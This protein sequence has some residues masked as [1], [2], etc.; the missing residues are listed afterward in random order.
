MKATISIEIDTNSLKSV[1][2]SYLE[3]LWYVA[4]ISARA[5]NTLGIKVSEDVIA[6]IV[7]RWLTSQP[8]SAW[9]HIGFNRTA[10]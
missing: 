8:P 10:D 9:A 4:N 2:D 5:G 3:Q 6:E 1:E 7:R